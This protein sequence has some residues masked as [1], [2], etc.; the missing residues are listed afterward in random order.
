MTQTYVIPNIEEIDRD[1]LY[2]DL[3]KFLSPEKSLKLPKNDTT[4]KLLTNMYTETEAYVI[5]YGFKKPLG[6]RL[7]WSIRRK[8]RI[9]KKELQEILVDMIY[10]GKLIKKGPFYL[11]F[12]YIPG[13]FEFYFTTNR[14]DPERMKKA[15]EAHDALF[16]EGYPLGLG[17]MDPTV[18]R[19]IPTIE[20]TKKTY[21]IN[22][23]MDLQHQIL[24]YELMEE[25]LAEKDV[26]AVV[27]CSCR[28]AAAL[29]GNPCKRTDENFCITAGALAKNSIDSGVGKEVTLEELIEVM[30][31]AEKE[32]LVH[33]TFN[34]QEASLFICNCCPCCCGF[35]KSV[36]ELGNYSSI[37]KSNFDP[38]IDFEECT[39]CKACVE[40][41][42]MEAISL[43]NTS[44]GENSPKI[45]INYNLCI[46][47]GVCASNCPQDAINLEKVRN[48]I[49][50]KN[51][52]KYY[53]KLE[54]HE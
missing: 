23:S 8:T 27:P 17:K 18:Y 31:K 43:K 7:G 6:P 12:P 26:F 20:P 36:K 50:V 13:G 33:E 48:I 11:I 2:E 51:L 30:K 1:Q 24:T 5:V 16:Y 40:I 14:D 54:R 28:T 47:C 21:K 34:V 22:K 38:H 46:G 3:R 35:L 25:Y 42:P 52:R 9:P 53:K 19:V 4:K 10:K 32:G 49:P 37:T 29:A 39:L 44:N 41:C 15:A 45:D